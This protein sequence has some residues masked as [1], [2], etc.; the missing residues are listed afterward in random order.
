M[1]ADDFII[2][3][4]FRTYTTIILRD[5]KRLRDHAPTA[6]AG[7][8][9][10]VVSAASCRLAGKL[11]ELLG[12]PVAWR[13]IPQVLAKFPALAF[14]ISHDGLPESPRLVGW[15][16]ED[17]PA[18]SRDAGA[19]GADVVDEDKGNRGGLAEPAAC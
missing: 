6:G 12:T 3:K 19:R 10:W 5:N 1:I 16:V 7:V 8:H 9:Y 13:D 15:P 11:A 18:R 4:D 17:D 14:G 2:T